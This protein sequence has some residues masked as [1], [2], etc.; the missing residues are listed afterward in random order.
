MGTTNRA[1]SEPPSPMLRLFTT[2]KGAD[3]KT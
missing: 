1:L 3:P 2:S